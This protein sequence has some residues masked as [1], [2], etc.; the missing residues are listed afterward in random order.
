MLR[1]IPGKKMAGWKRRV[2]EAF[3]CR[4]ANKGATADYQRRGLM[5]CT[6]MLVDKSRVSVV[7]EDG[8]V[9]STSKLEKDLRALDYQV[10]ATDDLRATCCVI[11]GR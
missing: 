6:Y 5:P 1:S 9:P 8:V 10:G 11:F 2:I 7:Q 4:E 3:G